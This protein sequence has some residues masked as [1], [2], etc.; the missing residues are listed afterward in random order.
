MEPIQT[1]PQPILDMIQKEGFFKMYQNYRAD[2][3]KLD[4]TNKQVYEQVEALYAAYYLQKRYADY[5]S[6]KS[7]YTRYIR[8]RNSRKK[9]LKNKAYHYE[10]I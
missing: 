5:A 3:D 2:P 7:Q 9:L 8:Q 1:Y 6:F 4:L 10:N